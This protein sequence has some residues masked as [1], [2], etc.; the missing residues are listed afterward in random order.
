M[1][2]AR[3]LDVV[4]RVENRPSSVQDSE[5]TR[6]VYDG[7]WSRVFDHVYAN[8]NRL[9]TLVVRSY[10][11]DQGLGGF[12]EGARDLTMGLLRLPTPNLEE[13]AITFYDDTRAEDWGAFRRAPAPVYLPFAP[14]LRSLQLVYTR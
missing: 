7:F 1:R 3:R 2:R 8:A 12:P 6:S 14:K 10:A 5:S 13:V 11:G 4:L 9:R